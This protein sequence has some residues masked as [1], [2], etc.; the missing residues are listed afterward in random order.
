[1]E[2]FRNLRQ[3]RIEEFHNKKKIRLELRNG[4]LKEIIV[5]KTYNY[6]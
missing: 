5:Y 1:M 4:M 6:L 3:K 2:D